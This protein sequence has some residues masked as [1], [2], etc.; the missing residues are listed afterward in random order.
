MITYFALDYF[1][2]SFI[3]IEYLCSVHSRKLRKGAPRWYQKISP[4]DV[5]APKGNNP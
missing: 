3:H 4:P 2:Y 5:S 1:D